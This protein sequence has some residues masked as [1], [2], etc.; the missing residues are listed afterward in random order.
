MEQARFGRISTDELP[1]ERGT[2]LAMYQRVRWYAVPAWMTEAVAERRAAGDV[3][4]ACAA[5]GIDLDVDLAKVKGACGRETADL[6]EDDLRHLV[7]DL[8]RWHMPRVVR[9]MGAIWSA[10]GVLRRYP[11]GGGANLVVDKVWRDPVRLELRVVT[12]R[13]GTPVVHDRGSHKYHLHRSCWDARHTDEL[14]ERCGGTDRIPFFHADG[15]PL[16]DAEL[17]D[18]GG[19]CPDDPV[20]AAEWLTTLWDRGRTGEALAACGIT[21]APDE[22]DLWPERPLVA[23][24]RLAADARNVLDHGVPEPALSRTRPPRDRRIWVDG[25]EETQV[26][27]DVELTFGRAGRVTA[28]RRNAPIGEYMALTVPEYRHPVDFDLL[29]FGYLRPDDLHPLVAGALFPA[30]DGAA[31][32]PLPGRITG[33]RPEPSQ[34]LLE[35]AYHGDTPGVMALLDAGVDPASRNEAGETLLHL[36][37]H[38]DHEVVLPRLLAAGL[39]VNTVDAEGHT[40][41]HAAAEWLSPRRRR[42]DLIDRLFDAGGMDACLKRGVTGCLGSEMKRTPPRSED[43]VWQS[44]PPPTSER[45]GRLRKKAKRG[46]YRSLVRLARGLYLTGLGPREVLAECFGVAFPDEFF[47]L[48]ERLPP[49]GHDTEEYDLHTW[50]LALPPGRGGPVAPSSRPFGDIDDDHAEQRILA[51]DPDL[52]PLVT[53]TGG[54]T[55]YSSLTLC[56]RSSE[57]ADGRTEIHGINVLDPDEDVE[58][59]GSSLRE[60]LRDHHAAVVERMELLERRTPGSVHQPW[61]AYHRAVLQQVEP[62]MPPGEDRAPSPE[63]PP[64]E[65]LRVQATRGD[66]R[67]MSRLARALYATGL[68]PREVLAECFGLT[69]PDEFFAIAGTDS[70]DVLPGWETNLPWGLAVP[71]DRGGPAARPSAM[72]WRPERRIFAFDPD[73]VPLV[74]L[75]GDDR[76]DHGAKKR[77]PRV[78]YGDRILC[79]SMGELAAGRST[80]IAVPWERAEEGGELFAETSGSSLLTVLHQYLSARHQL[81]EWEV[82][83]PWNR[84]AGS[85]DATEVEGSREAV[86]E[87]EALQRRLADQDGQAEQ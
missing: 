3:E 62:L 1:E 39:D 17:P 65:S 25:R 27:E 81:N 34:E 55:E 2:V 7:P 14:R 59:C 77:Q 18:T 4:G 54:H 72:M 23:V 73:L 8:L 9:P 20:A 52:I 31:G 32:P 38:L 60:V 41:L 50:K 37:A 44:K 24:E 80:V 66:Y 22:P 56:Y 57:L 46:S 12:P 43:E 86:A 40:A 63:P 61:L 85:I 48:A 11:A 74:A 69:F 33:D 47:A 42:D 84:G 58:R 29:R 67:T 53:L 28:R 49:E 26:V 76:I 82:M 70:R 51:R 16:D 13:A 35:R 15:R 21:L 36:L 78:P 30:R 6:V 10:S 68:N 5:A 71:P 83:Q 75:H 64:L 19:P 45:L 87:I 79:Y